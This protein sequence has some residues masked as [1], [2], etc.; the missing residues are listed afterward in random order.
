MKVLILGSGALKIGEAGEFDYSGS[1]ALKA[2]KEDVGKV[3]HAAKDRGVSGTT[4][5][6]KEHPAAGIGIV[7]IQ[8]QQAVDQFLGRLRFTQ[9]GARTLG[10]IRADHL[11]SH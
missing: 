6:A 9:R 3:A 8:T 2:L 4:E 11:P 10:I 5:W 7:A 1:Q